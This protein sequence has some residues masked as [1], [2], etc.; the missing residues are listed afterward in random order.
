MFK[1]VVSAR[2]RPKGWPVLAT[3]LVLAACQPTLHVGEWT[4]TEQGEDASIPD[5]SDPVAM[6]W[7]TGFEN[8]FCDY[9]QVAG[10][11]Y[12]GMGASYEIVSSPVHSGRSAAAFRITSGDMESYQTRC[13]RQ[14]VLPRAAY[15]GVWYFVPALAQNSALWNLLHFQGGS[16]SGAHGLWDVSLVTR[17][18]GALEATVFD[19]LNGR[20]HRATNP[21]PIPIGEWFHFEF[22]LKRAADRTGEVAL[23]QDGQLLLQVT[24]TITDDSEWGQWYLGNLATGLMPADSTLY[25]DDVTIR[26]SR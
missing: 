13:V 17:A 3:A 24:N 2:S 16:P 1:M 12:S 21:R 5:T 9:T 15:Y 7:S 6:P 14:G 22:Y 8:Q 26:E 23:Y 18:D 4:C 19:F 10:F 25:V 20:T 11:C